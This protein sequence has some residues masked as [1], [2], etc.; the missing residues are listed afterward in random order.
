MLCLCKIVWSGNVEEKKIVGSLNGR[1]I[2][3]HDCIF[4]NVLISVSAWVSIWSITEAIHA[5]TLLLC[6][7]NHY[8][9]R[10]NEPT[11]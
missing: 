5:A 9:T 8:I 10:Q 3:D 2:C 6:D 11:K 7:V 1:N 4:T